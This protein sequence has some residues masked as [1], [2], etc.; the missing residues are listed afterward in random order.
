MIDLP[1]LNFPWKLKNI[2]L[3]VGTGLFLLNW[4]YSY[5][6]SQDEKRRLLKDTEAKK[7]AALQMATRWNA[8]TSWDKS[9][10]SEKRYRNSPI[11]SY[12]IENLWI[13]DQPIFFVGTLVDISSA[14]DLHYRVVIERPRYGFS[15]FFDTTLRLSLVADRSDVESFIKTN[16]EVVSQSAD[17]RLLKRLAV[18]A[19]IDSI[20]TE[21]HEKSDGSLQAI[22]IGIGRMEDVTYVSQAEF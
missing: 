11:L 10:V 19:K 3:V 17:G 20:D 6:I 5:M 13:R 7:I 9:L 2:I 14:D 22:K 8:I 16:P 21:F 12:E 1:K 4:T 15:Y 18:I